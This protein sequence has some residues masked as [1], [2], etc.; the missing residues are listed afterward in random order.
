MNVGTCSV[1]EARERLERGGAMLDVREFPEYAEAHVAGGRL[2]PLGELRRSPERAGKGGELLL[3]CRSG[4]R[5]TEAAEILSRFGSV[6][7]IVI[8]GG[9]EAWKQAGYPVAREKGPISL[10]R[11][12]RIA[13]GALVV[14]GLLLDLVLPGARLLSGFVGAGLIFA[15]VTDTCAMGLLLA[16]LPGNRRTGA[17]GSAAANSKVCSTR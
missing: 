6:Q 2:L 5:A 11:Q 1:R 16:K 3:L 9:I 14:S 7:P 10:E 15:G 13:A 17:A 8:E 4:R 12:V